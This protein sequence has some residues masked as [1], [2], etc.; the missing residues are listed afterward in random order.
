M[1]QVSQ[2]GCLPSLLGDGDKGIEIVYG[3]EKKYFV[4]GLLEQPRQNRNLLYRHKKPNEPTMRKDSFHL[5]SVS[6]HQRG[7]PLSSLSVYL[8]LFTYFV[9][10]QTP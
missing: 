10:R 4:L 7:S 5:Y 6:P 9:C 1:R 3:E 2:L 8:H